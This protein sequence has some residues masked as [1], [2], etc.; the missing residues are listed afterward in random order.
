MPKTIAEKMMEGLGDTIAS[1]ATFP[2][3]A[4][5]GVIK[6]SGKDALRIIKRIFQPKVKKNLAQ[7]KNFTLHYG[8]VIGEQK[9]RIDEVLVAVMR[10]P[11][12]YT[13]EDVIEIY[14]HGGPVVLNA[15]V[16]LLIRQGARQAYPGEFTFRA[17]M[18]G[19]IDLPQAEAVRDIVEAGSLDAVQWGMRQLE[20]GLSKRVTDILRQ[21]RILRTRT[22]A[23]VSFPDDEVA[24]HERQAIASMNAL[25]SS[26]E[27]IVQREEETVVLR[28]GIRCVICGRPNVGKSSLFNTLFKDERVIV[29]AVA[30]TT[31][32]VIEERI[33]L[34]G[35]IFRLYDTAGL[36]DSRDTVH[37][38]A[39][40][41]ARTAIGQ[42]DIILF[43]FDAGKKL[44][45]YETRALREIISLKKKAILVL[46]KID[47]KVRLQKA[48][49][50]RYG[51]PVAEI[52]LKYEQGVE[53]LKQI[54]VKLVKRLTASGPGSA[55]EGYFNRR[56]LAAF[57]K[58][59]QLCGESLDCLRQKRTDM[60]NFKLAEMEEALESIVGTHISEDVID[61]V[62]RDFCIG[63]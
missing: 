53:T 54:L 34:E 40:L 32:D 12:S 13:R 5:V 55:D 43:L 21:V 41:R 47:L 62:F 17:F 25:R 2:S 11:C 49:L 39:V 45:A 10:R 23:M 63:K 60:V 6:L 36:W 44:S 29:S 33:N 24:F 3:Y 51:F 7:V 30:G 1:L 56:H 26:V 8:W 18:N 57:R 31:R 46:N 22:E 28:E 50:R 9:T 38:K 37:K 14:S 61:S 16:T 58:I 59:E 42:A 19:R 15:V 52:S 4:A 35:I 20:G 48:A 27:K